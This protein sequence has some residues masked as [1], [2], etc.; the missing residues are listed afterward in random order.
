[1]HLQTFFLFTNLSTFNFCHHPEERQKVSKKK[2]EEKR[3]NNNKITPHR[4]YLVA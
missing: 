4:E 1:M 2:I 3:E